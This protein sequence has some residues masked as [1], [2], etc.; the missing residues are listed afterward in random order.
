MFKGVLKI[1]NTKVLYF[2]MLCKLTKNECF[3][4][5]LIGGDCNFECGVIRP[6]EFMFVDRFCISSIVAELW[7]LN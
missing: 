3:L 5:S 2:T 1:L 4:L 6:A 7:M